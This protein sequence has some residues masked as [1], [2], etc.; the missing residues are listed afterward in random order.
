MLNDGASVHLMAIVLAATVVMAAPPVIAREH[1]LM[2]PAEAPVDWGM[3]KHAKLGQSDVLAQP[4]GVPID[5]QSPPSLVP[6]RG[7]AR[8][9]VW[10]NV[11][12]MDEE[13]N[14]SH[15]VDCRYRG[16]PRVL[17]LQ[18]DGLRQC[19]QTAQPYSAKGV[20]AVDARQTFICD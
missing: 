6:D 1:R 17:R 13:P 5:E 16:S 2:C 19:E 4:I 11:W 7:Y 15:F 10:H 12:L 9:G 20:I 14:W 3:G 8:G 18:A